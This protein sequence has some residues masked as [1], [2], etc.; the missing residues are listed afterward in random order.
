M[1]L[2]LLQLFGVFDTVAAVSALSISFRFWRLL[3]VAFNVS[4]FDGN[5]AGGI[6][7]VAA[8]V[9]VEEKIEKQNS[10]DLHNIK[11]ILVEKRR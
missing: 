5:I 1:E 6:F 2:L 7:A 11:R 8:A 9:V 3:V 4:H 10:R